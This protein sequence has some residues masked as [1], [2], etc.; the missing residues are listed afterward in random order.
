MLPKV[1][2]TQWAGLLRPLPFVWC[3]VKMSFQKPGRR[4]KT[5]ED[6]LPVS[7]VFLD[8]TR[9]KV[10][11]HC[12]VGVTGRWVARGT[13]SSINCVF[14][15]FKSVLTAANRD[16]QLLFPSFFPSPIHF[17]FTLW[18]TL[19][20]PR[21]CN[22]NFLCHISETKSESLFCGLSPKSQSCC[23]RVGYRMK[24]LQNYT[25]Q[26]LNGGSW[27]TNIPLLSLIS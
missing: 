11:H 21:I 24:M 23:A 27:H 10:F 5:L 8:R 15:S 13:G 9:E 3:Q 17:V 26:G 16:A 2:V 25:H 1:P 7:G 22:C 18:G 14:M 6:Q 20:I 12:V 19:P 4:T